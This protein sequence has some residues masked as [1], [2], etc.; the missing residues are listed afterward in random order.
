MS[1]SPHGWRVKKVKERLTN[2][3]EVNMTARNEHLS[4]IEQK[5]RHV[6]DRS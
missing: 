3:L 5:I 6:K 4:E 2:T 1:D